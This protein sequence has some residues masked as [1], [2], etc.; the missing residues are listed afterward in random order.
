MKTDYR[1]RK[2][3][4]E[5]KTIK[6]DGAIGKRFVSQT[7]PAYDNR[8]HPQYRARNK[9]GN[10]TVGGGVGCV[11]VGGGNGRSVGGRGAGVGVGGGGRVPATKSGTVTRRTDGI[12]RD[13]NRL[14]A[15]AP[16]IAVTGLGGLRVIKDRG[17]GMGNQGTGN[18]GNQG[19]ARGN[20]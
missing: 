6:Q 10:G 16:A 17:M 7:A 5:R 8:N 12:R 20:R 3:A 14:P 18:Q 9:T 4:R 1:K 19:R 15:S 2:D 13:P 11:G